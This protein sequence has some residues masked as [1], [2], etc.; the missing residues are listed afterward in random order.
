M[1]LVRS[2]AFNLAGMFAAIVMDMWEKMGGEVIQKEGI[3]IID[4][5]DA[6]A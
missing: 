6:H 1:Y 3:D 2:A 4:A 5:Y